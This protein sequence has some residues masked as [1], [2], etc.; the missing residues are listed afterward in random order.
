ME[1]VREFVI[2]KTYKQEPELKKTCFRSS[3]G[4]VM[5]Q[6]CWL[7]SRTAKVASNSIHYAQTAVLKVFLTV[8]CLSRIE[9]TPSTNQMW[10]GVFDVCSRY[11]IMRDLP[12]LMM[13]WNLSQ[14]YAHVLHYPVR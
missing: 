5:K 1:G 2:P 11:A 4:I 8:H 9:N 12:T 13:Y 14:F 6:H 10:D 7:F 3:L